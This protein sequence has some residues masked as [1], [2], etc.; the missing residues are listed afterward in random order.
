MD[1]S[2]ELE[3]ESRSIDEAI[4]EACKHFD[5]P[6]EKL[7]IEILSDAKA[8]IFG[9]GA[10][11]ASIRVKL[12]ED[13][14]ELR[15]LI[16][17]IIERLTAPIVGPLK[18]DMDA[19]TDRV[20]IALRPDGDP[21]VL[22]GRD[23]QTLSSIQYLT[24]RILAKRW[25]GAPVRVQIDVGDYREQQDDSLRQLAFSLAERVKSS[26]KPQS[27]KPLSSYHRRVVHLALQ[28]DGAILTR[29]KG[30][31]PLKRVLILPKRERQGQRGQRPPQGKASAG[32]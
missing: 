17:S 22:I 24:N 10:Q 6:R 27:T 16:A 28:E 32:E 3:F 8:G 4:E 5:V 9:L 19:E 1:K 2:T 11:K 30:D 14:F 7:E 12:R 18:F 21:E 13:T 20:K 25:T 23:G 29:S 31:G 15:K 26:G